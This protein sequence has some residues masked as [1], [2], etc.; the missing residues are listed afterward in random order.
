MAKKK[1][2]FVSKNEDEDEYDDN[3]YDND[4]DHDQDTKMTTA[5]KGH[6]KK[7]SP[8]ASSVETTLFKQWRYWYL[9][10]Q[11]RYL[12]AVMICLSGV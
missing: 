1:W 10:S 2:L 4:D 7:N 11:G 12:K 3:D 6:V 9:L 8:G 5:C